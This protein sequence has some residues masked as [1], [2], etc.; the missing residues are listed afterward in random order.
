MADAPEGPFALY[1]GRLT[2]EDWTCIDAT[3]YRRDGHNYMIFSHSFEDGATALSGDMCM[4]ELSADLKRAI[5]E[6]VVLFPAC[7]APW[8]TPVPFARDEFGIEGDAYFTDGPFLVEQRDGGLRMY[9]SSWSTHGYAVGEA[10]SD[11]GAV[12]GP[13]RQVAEPFFP[14]NG[15]HGMAF[16]RFDGRLVY[17]LHYPNDKY[18]EH[19]IFTEIE[20]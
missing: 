7:A 19:P 8:A 17:V 20:E 15:G 9:W 16:R 1:S 10:V 13:W 11:S 3:L 4:V 5:T 12:T 18:L 2:P 6:P 14:E